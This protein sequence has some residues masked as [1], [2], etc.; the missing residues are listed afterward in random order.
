[1]M[2]AADIYTAE[3]NL[4][5]GR[6]HGLLT[7]SVPTA[8]LVRRLSFEVIPSCVNQDYLTVSHEIL[9]HLAH[10]MT[11]LLKGHYVVLEMKFKLRILIFTILMR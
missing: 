5:D 1:M 3:P 7:K 2:L 6:R 9:L 10:T 11:L 8:I 4:K